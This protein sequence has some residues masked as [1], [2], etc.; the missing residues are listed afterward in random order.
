[1]L[2]FTPGP[3]EIEQSIRDIGS[4]RLPYFRGQ[5]YTEMMLELTENLKYLFQ[6]ENTPL[7]LTSSGSG[8]MEMALLNLLNPEDKVVVL[9]CGTFGS[10]WVTM[11]RAFGIIPHE[12]KADL[13]KIP[14]LE[15]LRNALADDIKAVLVTAHETST[16][17]LNDVK[18]IGTITH[19]KGVLL[20]VDAVSSIGA[21]HFLM[22]EWNCDC[23]VVSSQKALACMPGISFIA[24]NERAWEV[25]PEVR[26]D[27]YYFDA[28]EYLKN[29][30]RG[31]VPYT[32]AMNVTFQV[33]ER[34]HRIRR[35]GIDAYI[36]QHITKANVFRER[37]L[38]SGEFTLFAE[39]QSNALT[40]I[41]LPDGCSMSEV[42]SF[43]REKYDWYLAPN[44]THDERYLRVA[45]MGDIT[46]D[47]LL[48]LADKI[49]E[50]C[51]YL[52]RGSR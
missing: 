19:P 15:E 12:I 28:E 37:I 42:I 47:N 10:K 18:E 40:S 8:V 2:L 45:H 7:T 46:I 13:G 24:F 32:P 48:E 52:R 38:N 33:H 34:L 29:I 27:R 9:N 49:E 23:A 41:R 51:H 3:T 44:P 26:R 22:D 35:S 21:D 50:A 17:L 43:I 25:I 4:M 5:A 39:R 30:R 11:C 14:D 20:I 6:T 36:D 31:M 1:M 16:G